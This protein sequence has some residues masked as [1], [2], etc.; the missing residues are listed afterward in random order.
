MQVHAAVW[1]FAE[2]NGSVYAKN[3]ERS[4]QE[5]PDQSRQVEDKTW[6]VKRAGLNQLKRWLSI[7]IEERERLMKATPDPVHPM[8][9]IPD[10]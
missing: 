2:R 3:Y 6:L 8:E 7:P 9:G 10:R 1:E 5:L 4:Q